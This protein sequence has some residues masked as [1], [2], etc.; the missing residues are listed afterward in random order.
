MVGIRVFLW[1]PAALACVTWSS[2]WR[3]KSEVVDGGFD[4]SLKELGLKYIMSSIKNNHC[5]TKHHE[6]LV[7]NH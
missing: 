4:S 5:R 1:Q 7:R 6:P 3:K 2:R